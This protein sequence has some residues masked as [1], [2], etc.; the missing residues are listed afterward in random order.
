MAIDD[1]VVVFSQ[2]PAKVLALLSGGGTKRRQIRSHRAARRLFFSRT[3]R[4]S[5]A[6][7]GPPAPPFFVSSHSSTWDFD[8]VEHV[9]AC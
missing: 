2:Q 4:F 1:M 9:T 8:D 3:V 5:R 7:Y 6:I